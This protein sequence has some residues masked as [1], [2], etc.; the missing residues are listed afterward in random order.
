M[1]KRLFL[2]LLV[3]LVV[4]FTAWSLQTTEVDMEK[5][6][7]G[8]FVK[9][10]F[11]EFLQGLWPPN[12]GIL[13][14]VS[15]Q[16]LVTI[17]MAWI[18]TVLATAISLP[19]SFV[20]ARNITPAVAVGALTRFFFNVDR[21]ID[22]LIVALILVSAVGLGPLAG[23]LALAVHSVGSMGKLFAEAIETIDRGPIEALE[24]TGASRSQVIRWGVVPQVMPLLV[25]NFFYRLE[26]NIRSSVILGIVGAGGIGFMLYDNIKQFQYQNVSMILVVIIG[27]VMSIDYVSGKL[28]KATV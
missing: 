19:L 7:Q 20:A 9:P 11:G 5:I 2:Y 25:S 3:A 21:S 15:W 4:G 28:R 8:F 13:G 26:L 22:V 14:E 24:S 1:S 23:V 12:W 18:G 17:Q 16:M 6:R 10:F 27:V